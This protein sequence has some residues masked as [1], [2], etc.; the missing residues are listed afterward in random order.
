[1]KRL[2]FA[3]LLCSCGGGENPP[4][5][6]VAIPSQPAT[7][8]SATA[9]SLPRAADSSGPRSAANAAPRVVIKELAVTE[10]SCGLDDHGRVWLWGTM[11]MERDVPSIEGAR[12][13]GCYGNSHA[14]VVASDATVL[15]WGWNSYG[16]L[17][18]GTEKSHT[19]DP[20]RVKGLASVAEIG[21]DFNRTCAR[22][23]NGDVYC[24]GDSEFGKA[25]DGRLPDNVGREKLLPGKPILA[26]A[27]TLSVASAH[28]CSV[29]TDGRISC[30]GQNNSLACGQPPNVRYA[31]RPMIVPKVKDAVSVSAG[32]S[33]T[34][35]LDK[36]GAV[37]C[38]GEEPIDHKPRQTPVK[39]PLPEKAVQIVV[40]VET[41]ACAR[42]ASGAVHCWGRNE[43]GELGDGTKIDRPSPVAVKGI[44]NATR[45]GAGLGDT[46]ALLGDGRVLCRGTKRG[47]DDDAL[48]PVELRVAHER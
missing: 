43:N 32:G 21:L 22:T 33:T 10:A 27:T 18:D 40:G 45:I 17:G 12:M 9:T 25:G 36:D 39:V 41:H 46:C 14:C 1:M 34:C 48:T 35:M 30:W 44:T 28:A 2:A 38:W 19:D 47:H 16:A 20:V 13:I 31:A 8:A 3:A 26:G 6:V 7:R 5:K 24:W 42:L 23:T 11:E 15:C 29:L 4:S 37:S